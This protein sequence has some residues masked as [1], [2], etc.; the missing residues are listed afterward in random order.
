ML[1]PLRP[2]LAVVLLAAAAPASAFTLAFEGIDP[3]GDQLYGCGLEINGSDRLIVVDPPAVPGLAV[4]GGPSDLFLDGNESIYF[5][6]LD[7]PATSVRY[8]VSE[9]VVSGGAT[10]E[11]YDAEL[12]PI[13]SKEV[14]GAGEKDVSALF[15]GVP[16]GAFRV[17]NAIGGHRIGSVSFQPPGGAVTVEL[18]DAPDEQQDDLKYCGVGFSVDDGLFYVSAAGLGIGSAAGT[19]DFF[20]EPGEGLTVELDEP[21]GGLSYAHTSNG[22]G[23]P[24]A[25][26]TAFGATGAVLGEVEVQTAAPVDVTALF[27]GASL[28]GFHL[29]VLE[30]DLALAELVIVPEAGAA[31]GG[32]AALC[33]LAALRRR[34]SRSE[35][36]SPA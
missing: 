36:V 8:T 23:V 21:V 31:A 25:R 32:A 34:Y 4:L 14:S 9:I 22:P 18:S 30:G 29:A 24:R 28:T 12:D 11:A 3:S 6:F 15:G 20:L 19:L 10:I 5:E 16:L 27:G 13:G 17:T 2:A 33:A 35:D 26:V 1:R 7:G